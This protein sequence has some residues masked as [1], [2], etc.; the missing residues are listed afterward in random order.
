VP[1]VATRRPRLRAAKPVAKAMRGEARGE[2]PGR[3]GGGA[4]MG[5]SGGR[6]G[7]VEREE[8]G[9]AEMGAIGSYLQA[10]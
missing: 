7:R 5:R 1:R 2:G 8:P 9:A 3:P 6:E 10:A 4:W